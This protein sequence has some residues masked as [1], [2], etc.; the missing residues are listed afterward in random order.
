[1]RMEVERRVLP[2]NDRCRA[3]NG[4]G[5][6][7]DLDLFERYR[8]AFG[9]GQFE[10]GRNPVDRDGNRRRA[11]CERRYETFGADRGDGLIR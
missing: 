7:L 4:R 5:S 6:V 2:E 9:D 11:D 1:M 10:R 8:N 3:L